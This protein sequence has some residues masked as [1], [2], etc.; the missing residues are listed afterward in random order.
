VLFDAHFSF[1]VTQGTNTTC[2]IVYPPEGV[3]AIFVYNQGAS[4][5]GHAVH[6]A[7][8]H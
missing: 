4:G 6:P 8:M 1:S 5:S 2:N 7:R 3:N